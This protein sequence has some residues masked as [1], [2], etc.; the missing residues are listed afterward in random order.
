MSARGGGCRSPAPRGGV[1]AACQATASH[2]ASRPHIKI[3]PID[4][5]WLITISGVHLAVITKT[6]I[7]VI[8]LIVIK[9]KVED[10]LRGQNEES[11]EGLRTAGRA[12]RAAAARG[13]GMLPSPPP[14]THYC[15]C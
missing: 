10:S 3:C 4:I 9:Y 1:F 7:S 6:I 13:T 2:Q 12:C 5:R 15:K 8:G 14:A 11:L